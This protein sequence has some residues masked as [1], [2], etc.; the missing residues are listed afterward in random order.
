MAQAVLSRGESGNALSVGLTFG[1]AV[2]M[3]VYVCGGI[4][5]KLSIIF[6]LFHYTFIINNCTVIIRVMV[7]VFVVVIILFC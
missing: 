4:S 7:C 6:I 5:G 3:G 1:M 2:T